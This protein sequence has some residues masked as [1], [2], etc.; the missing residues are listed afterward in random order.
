[1][2]GERLDIDEDGNVIG[3]GPHYQFDSSPYLV[4]P[5]IA[6]SPSQDMG[7]NNIYSMS[8]D[9]DGKMRIT[10]DDADIEIDGISLKKTLHKLQERMAILEPNLELEQEFKELKDIRKKY[11]EL[12][13]N[14]LEKKA[15][16]QALNQDD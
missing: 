2:S 7:Y 8:H 6:I 15:I 12:E 5:T 3:I 11:I 9:I 16:W 1:M 10:G 13:R 14:L 4:P